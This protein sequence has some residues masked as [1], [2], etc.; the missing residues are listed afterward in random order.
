ML[1]TNRQTDKQTAPNIVP[2]STDRVGVGNNH[3]IITIYDCN[4]DNGENKFLT[5]IR[6]RLLLTDS[7][8]RKNGRK[9]VWKTY[10]RRRRLQ[11]LE[12]LYENNSYE[13]LKRTAEDRSA[14]RESTTKKVLKLFKSQTSI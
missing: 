5:K 2:T 14:W 13:V 3:F 8:G 12:D 1:Q 11:M 7:S 9:N 6:T 4:A 10:E